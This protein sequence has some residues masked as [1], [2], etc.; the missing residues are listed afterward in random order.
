MVLGEA[1]ALPGWG[2]S[3]SVREAKAHLSGLLEQVV[4][5]GKEFVI[6]S[7][8]KPKVKVMPVDA[9]PRRKEFPGSAA[10]LKTMPMRPGPSAEELIRTDRDGRGW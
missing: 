4:K 1:A 6:T 7:D 8:G 10:H 5:T 3:I 2:G 9:K